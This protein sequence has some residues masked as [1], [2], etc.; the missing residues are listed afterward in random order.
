M[1]ISGSTKSAPASG[2][3]SSATMPAAVKPSVRNTAL[4]TPSRAPSQ[5]QTSLPAPPPAKTRVSASPTVGSSAPLSFSR[6]GRK[7][8]NP[9]RVA[10]SIIAIDS[11]SGNP[12]PPAAGGGGGGGGGAA[13]AHTP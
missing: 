11:S 8:R 5:P 2:N 4:S 1:P 6:N 12:R 10:L 9:I 3:G 13:G 7:V